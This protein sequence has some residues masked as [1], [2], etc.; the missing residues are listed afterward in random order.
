MSERQKSC[1]VCEATQE[2]MRCSQCLEVF[3]C[4]KR[5]QAKH[6]KTHRVHCEAVQEQRERSGGKAASGEEKHVGPT[7]AE[8]L[9]EARVTVI[10]ISIFENGITGDAV[11]V[12]LEQFETAG[13]LV[14]RAI[15]T[16][17]GRWALYRSSYNHP[18]DADDFLATQNFDQHEL[19]VARQI[20]GPPAI[21]G[22][23][24]ESINRNALVNDL[25]PEGMCAYR[26]D[27]SVPI[28]SK[29]T[30]SRLWHL[31]H[32]RVGRPPALLTPP[33]R[34]NAW[35]A[36]VEASRL[37]EWLPIFVVVLLAILIGW[38]LRMQ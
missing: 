29:K 16:R 38:F 32:L 20:D 17:G 21:E 7:L 18:L 6:W 28:G 14:E 4:G 37:W 1:A 2:L 33:R 34:S 19:L 35:N 5:H 22:V 25:I 26:P 24:L 9:R 23:S 15:G 12:P 13:Q 11:L 36:P 30:M 3:Y 8:E 27:S 10:R 31:S